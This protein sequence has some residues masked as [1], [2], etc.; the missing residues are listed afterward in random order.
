MVTAMNA[1]RTKL[2]VGGLWVCL[3]P[4]ACS[5]VLDIPSDPRLAATGPWRCVGQSLAV[6]P[7]V[8]INAQANVVVQACNFI[9]DCTT[10]ATG[11]M[12]R[13]CD[14]RDVGCN[15]P[16]S[17]GITDMNG[18]L[19]FQVPT[20]GGGFDGYLLVTSQVASCTDAQAFGAAAG[21]TLCDLASPMCDITAPDTRCYLPVYAPAMLFFNPPIVADIDT[22]LPLQLFPTSGLPAVIGAA[23]IQVDPMAGNLFIQALDCDGKPASGVTYQMAQYESQVS[24]L[25]VDNGIVSES[26]T[27]TD[28]TGVGGFVRVPPGFVSV[29]GYN[30]DSVAVG[31]I[32]VQAAPSVLTYSALLPQ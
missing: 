30:S 15:N 20:A 25:Y 21:K 27:H 4:T 14:K 3:T 24:P 17:T 1:W 28:S 23:G 19:R 11:L 9:S 13:V 6:A 8:P 16:R 32:G 5:E 26:V 22:P 7:N 29:T 10:A 31:E 18:E 12:A 2:L